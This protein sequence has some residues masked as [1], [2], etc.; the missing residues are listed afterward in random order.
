MTTGYGAQR[1][2]EQTKTC[3]KCRKADAA[4]GSLNCAPCYITNARLGGAGKSPQIPAPGSPVEPVDATPDVPGTQTNP[5]CSA[6]L[7][8]ELSGP[9]GV[10]CRWCF[11]LMA[12]R[13]GRRGRELRGIWRATKPRPAN[14]GG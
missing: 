11:E 5:P 7:C 1:D 8:D 12:W 10:L 6:S 3:I 14:T 4:P 2:R 13:I 9:G